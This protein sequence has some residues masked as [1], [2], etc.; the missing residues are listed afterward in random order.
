MGKS[1]YIK[2]RKEKLQLTSQEGTEVIVPLHGPL[3]TADNVVEALKEH[4]GKN[5][6]I[7]FHLDI[8]SNVGKMLE[9]KIASC[10]Q[11]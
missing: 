4:I 6:A 7:I 8:A 10:D 11:F 1:L 3:V 5:H 9:L 2:R